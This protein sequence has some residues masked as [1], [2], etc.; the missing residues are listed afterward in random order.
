MTALLVILMI[1]VMV[2][3]NVAVVARRRR[4]RA[5]GPVQLG[6]M[7]GPLLPHGLFLDAA[8]T[9]VRLHSDGTLRVGI[10]DFLAEALGRIDEILLPPAGTSVT[11]GDPLITIRVGQRQLSVP[12]PAT[13]EVRSLNTDAVS[14]PGL[15]MADPYGL[16][17]L[18]GIWT[19]DQK[20]AIAPLQ[21]G[22]GAIAHLRGE[23]ERLLDFLTTA[24]TA[25]GAPAQ[26]MAGRDL[27]QR[28]AVSALSDQDWAAFQ[29]HFLG[30]AAG[31]TDGTRRGAGRVVQM[32]HL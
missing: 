23:L 10:D 1:L 2:S 4:R 17:W 5:P 7:R 30:P 14:C 32:R 12:A 16:G 8:H 31:V 25:S 9:W 22:N 13:G 15:A 3:V 20:E 27:P 28:G 24:S 18:V 6:P 11:R 21:V 19:R 29:E 26:V